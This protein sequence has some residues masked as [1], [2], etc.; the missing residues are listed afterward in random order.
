LNNDEGVIKYQLDYRQTPPLDAA[1]IR[2]LNAWRRILYQLQLIGRD[3][4]RYGGYGYGNVSVRDPHDRHRFIISG[5]QTAHIPDTT[6]EHYVL[7]TQCDAV[8]NAL[9]ARGPV[10][11]SSEALTH[12]TVYQ[13]DAGIQFVFHIHNPS[14]WHHA[15]HLHIPST[16]PGVAYGT[17]EMATE[18]Q[19]L[20]ADPHIKEQAII[21]M[22]GH[23]DGIISFAAT[24]EQAG[25]T[26][27][28][29]LAL[30]QQC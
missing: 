3:E 27:I 26:L 22:A 30:A 21:K 16:D 10:K 25:V 6:V 12:G 19:R 28:K 11:P 20:I 4:Q 18:I 23:E 7:V 2:E 15:D 9:T 29:Y 24:A 5:T 14:I 8:R 13:S 1:L 17:P